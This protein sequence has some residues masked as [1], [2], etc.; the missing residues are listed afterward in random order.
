MNR[1]LKVVAAESIY[2]TSS[3]TCIL[4]GLCHNRP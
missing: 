4:C 2:S 3:W 1:K